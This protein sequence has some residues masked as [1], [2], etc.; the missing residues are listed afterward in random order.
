MILYFMRV[1]NT[2]SL[3]CI[4]LF[5]LQEGHSTTQCGIQI[6]DEQLDRLPSNPKYVEADIYLKYNLDVNRLTSL[7]QTISW[8]RV[9][10]SVISHENSDLYLF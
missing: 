4:S 10:I 1:F 5:Y 6:T 8:Y 9:I 7:N 2:I 3:L